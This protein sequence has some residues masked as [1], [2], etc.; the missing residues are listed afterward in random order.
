MP[1]LPPAARPV[2]LIALAAVAGALAVASLCVG[3]P[4]LSPARVARLVTSDD[5]SVAH[6]V[7][8]ELRIPRALVAT[9]AGATLGLVG[10][11]LQQA[12]DNPLASPELTG[13]SSGA[14]LV[15]AVVTVF[16]LPVAPGLAPWLAAAGGL[17]AAMIVLRAAGRGGDTVRMALGG[18][19]IAALLNAVLIGA[20]SLGTDDDVTSLYRYLVGSLRDRRWSDV[21]VAVPLVALGSAV[22]GGSVGTL[23]AMRVGD[24]AATTLGIRPV[25]V[26]LT[27][28]AG[29]AMATAGVVAVAGPLPFVGLAVPHL[30]RRSLATSDLRW[31]ATGSALAG[32][33]LLLGSD[34]LARIVLWPR[35]LPVGLFT[36]AIGAPVT[37]AAVRLRAAGGTP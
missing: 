4:V 9:L 35:E 7:M 2:A 33:A 10:A 22:L 5:G 24:A 25:R 37:L 20:L 19:A 27:V 12:L 36:V 26:R 8:H 18:A 29:A 21:R 13:V 32:A 16:D 6:L 34:V 17:G 1:P 28:L 15:V 11:T 3:V 23:N 30:V 14:A 31:V